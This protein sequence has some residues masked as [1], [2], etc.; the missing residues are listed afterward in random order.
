MAGL[1]S[2]LGLHL[3]ASLEPCIP[4]AFQ[5]PDTFE[6]TGQE[7]PS[8]DSRR[9]VRRASAVGDYLPSKTFLS[10]GTVWVFGGTSALSFAEARV[11]PA[12]R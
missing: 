3:A 1:N 9:F 5:H 12:V 8:C 7:G 4:A 6:T 2:G 11:T 10:F